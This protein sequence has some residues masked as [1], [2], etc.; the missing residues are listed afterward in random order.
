MLRFHFNHEWNALYFEKKS[1]LCV[2]V[3]GERSSETQRRSER[4]S[5]GGS[6]SWGWMG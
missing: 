1:I 4:K 6:S 3:V 2:N 5:G